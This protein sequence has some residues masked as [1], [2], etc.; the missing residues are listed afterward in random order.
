MI[1]RISLKRYAIICLCLS[2]WLYIAYG[3]MIERILFAV[4]ICL[5]CLSLDRISF[6]FVINLQNIVFGF[7]ICTFLMDFFVAFNITTLIY[8]F[9][10]M[11]VY[12]MCQSMPES[13][14]G[15]QT[16][17]IIYYCSVVTWLIIIVISILRTGISF[18][19][20]RGITRNPNSMG[21]LSGFMFTFA[22][23]HMLTK[24][25]L[26]KVDWIVL[27]CSFLLV[28]FSSCRTAFVCCIFEVLFGAV[29]SSLSPA[30]VIKKIF[31]C[32]IIFTIGYLVLKRIGLLDIIY[33]SIITK[34]DYY[35]RTLEDPTNGR[36]EMWELVWKRGKLLGSGVPLVGY[37]VHN[38]FLGLANQFGMLSGFSFLLFCIVY[39]CKA[40][41]VAWNGDLMNWTLLPLMSGTYFLFTAMTENYM[42]TAPMIVMFF[43]L[44]KLKDSQ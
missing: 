39:V 17:D 19:G 36:L 35:S 11:I 44:S 34:F 33:N 27:I 26:K 40:V 43:G 4:S 12:I 20:Y 29:F 15:K 9:S 21:H 32:V 16:F 24:H 7:F 5:F 30:I 18:V 8:G 14:D 13:M 23:I 28:V 31:V 42:M 25:S 3:Q 10:M 41:K 1:Y 22:L 6:S 37:T 38:V 2:G